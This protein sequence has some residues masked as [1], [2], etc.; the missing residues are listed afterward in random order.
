MFDAELKLA[1]HG[2]LD[3]SRPKNGQ[4]CDGKDLR[5]ALDLLLE[6]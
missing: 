6:N 1:Y 5:N 3:S 2:Q 4:T